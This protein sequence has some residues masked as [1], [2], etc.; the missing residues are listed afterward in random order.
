MDGLEELNRDLL[1]MGCEW[2]C[3]GAG[4]CDSNVIQQSDFVHKGNC[5]RKGFH[6]VPS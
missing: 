1:V 6:Y 3:G 2:N 5:N 4:R